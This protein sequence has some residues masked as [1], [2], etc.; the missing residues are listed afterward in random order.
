MAKTESPPLQRQIPWVLLGLAVGL[1][2][3]RLLFPEPF[4]S[5]RGEE[6]GEPVS[7]LVQWQKPGQLPEKLEKPVLYD[8]TAS[9]CGPCRRLA[10]EVWA[11]PHLASFIN[12]HFVPV[13]VEEEKRQEE[14]VKEL[15][16]R[17]HVKAFPT[18]ILTDPQ[19]HL[20]QRL[21]GFA[22][23]GPGKKRLAKVLREVVGE[24]G[25]QTLP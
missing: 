1:M 17:F 20:L 25:G 23:G 3:L 2:I 6:A 24:K 7:E 8:F 14:E 13:K 22:P 15:F 9:W 5:Q 11:D 16:Q 21:E 18:V 19:G 4:L 10:R 12:Q